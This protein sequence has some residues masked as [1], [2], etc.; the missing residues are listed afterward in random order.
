MHL[1][2]AGAASQH[3]YFGEAHASSQKR[4]TL[5]WQFFQ[6]KLAPRSPSNR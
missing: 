4:L 2:E 6:L 5:V 3:K 1:D